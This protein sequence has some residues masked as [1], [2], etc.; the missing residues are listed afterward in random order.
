[1]FSNT[2]EYSDLSFELNGRSG[3]SETNGRK[4]I[5]PAD[6]M[7]DDTLT[8]IGNPDLTLI[9]SDEIAVLVR[10][11]NFISTK[12]NDVVSESN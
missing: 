4:A 5:L 1:M 10:L 9:R 11:M 2:G 12:L 3:Q 6:V 7:I 8:P